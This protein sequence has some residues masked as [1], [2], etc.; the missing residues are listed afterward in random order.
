M[1]ASSCRA[2]GRPDLRPFVDLGHVPAITGALLGS[3]E[4]ARSAATGR[5]ELVVCD[6]CAH[7]E[8]TAFEPALVDYDG[9]YD[10]SLH[11]SAA[12]REYSRELALRLSK[13]YQLHGEH[14]VEIGSGRG[15]FLVE[16]CEVSGAS[17]T[18]YDP[19]CIPD[20]R[21]EG[22]EF[23]QE[24][25]VPGDQPGSYRLLVSRHVLEHLDDPAALLTSL[26]ADAARESVLYLEVP[27]A[28]FNFSAAGMWDCIYP[29]VSYFCQSSLEALLLRTGF[30]VLDQGR[31]FNGQFLWAE[32]RPGKAAPTGAKG[33]AGHL[34]ELERFAREWRETVASWQQRV[35]DQDLVLWGAGAKGV[36]FLN[37]VDR[38]ARMSVVDLNP[39]KWG[40][41][42][43]G[44]GHV[45]EAPAQ[46]VALDPAAVLITNPAYA[47]EI[48]ADLKALGLTADVVT[49]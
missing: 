14:V 28:E 30:E 8:N 19:T 13:R 41:H 36:T 11:F 45:V 46:L 38:D 9:D 40:R 44:T 21:Q 26:R 29:H 2:C 10:N 32:V 17:G 48:A 22:V 16:L 43:P 18:G 25:F 49:V 33:R 4:E 7:V 47:S 31:S 20:L 34:G 42:L 5:L 1:S 15:D 39:R 35:A 12:I 6:A 24:Y 27:A 37:A 23:R 3:A